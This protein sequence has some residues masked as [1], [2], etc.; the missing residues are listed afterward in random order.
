MFCRLLLAAWLALTPIAAQANL[1]NTGIGPGF[2]TLTCGEATTFL[3]R[4]PAVVT[5]SI[6]TTVLTVTG[7][8]S[9]TLAVGQTLSGSGVTAGTKITSLGTGTGGNGTYNLDTS[10]TAVSETVTAGQ[11]A[12]HIAGYTALICGLVADGLWTGFDALYVMATQDSTTAGFNLVS[13]SY[14]LT[15]TNAPVFTA[16]RGYTAAATGS[17]YVN[18]SAVLNALTQFTQNSASM[19]IFVGASAG[20]AAVEDFGASD[21]TAFSA[22]QSRNGANSVYRINNAGTSNSVANS[23]DVGLFVANRPSSATAEGYLNGVNALSTA[24][25]STAIPAFAPF[26]GARNGSGTASL[27]TTRTYS[28]AWV[29]R[30]FT[31]LEQ[32]QIYRIVV[33]WLTLVGAPTT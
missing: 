2:A 24:S 27:I 22:V 7:V 13:T 19:G 3:A 1:L 15:P 33:Q 12:T 10:Q 14:T 26:I 28:M 30:R 32:L 25:A 20:A 29:G 21:G 31:A 18:T 5:G 11:D 4:A 9:G 16:D 6:A 17:K 23:T 8:T